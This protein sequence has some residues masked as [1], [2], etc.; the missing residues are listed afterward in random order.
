MFLRWSW[1]WWSPILHDNTFA[2]LR[3]RIALLVRSMDQWIGLL[4]LFDILSHPTSRISTK[5]NRYY[6]ENT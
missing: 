6:H 3:P 2:L 5:K 4:V 1:W